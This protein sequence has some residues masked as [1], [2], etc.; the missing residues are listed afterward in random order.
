MVGDPGIEPGTSRLGGVTVRCRTLQHVA[1][2]RVKYARGRGASRRKWR[3]FGGV[4]TGAQTGGGGSPP[5]PVRTRPNPPEPL[6]R[7]GGGH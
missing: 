7:G 1:H 4:G 2:W 6:V 5:E 3:A